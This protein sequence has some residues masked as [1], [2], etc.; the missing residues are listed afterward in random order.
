MLPDLAHQ[1]SSFTPA[2]V[3]WIAN[4]QVEGNPPARRLSLTT[5]HS[6]LATSFQQVCFYETP[7]V[8]QI[9]ARRIATS[10]GES[11]CRNICG[12]KRCG[13]KFLRQRNRDTAR[14]RADIGNPQSVAIGLLRSAGATFSNGKA[15][16]YDFDDVLSFRARDQHVPRHFKFKSPEFLLPGKM[17]RRFTRSAA[18]DKREVT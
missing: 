7:A 11:G 13:G 3:G 2:N 9:V 5:R 18:A 17:L 12:H 1:C 8:C 10:D 6:P 15:V 4:N 16:Q 14:A